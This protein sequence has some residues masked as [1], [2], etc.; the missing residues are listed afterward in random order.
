MSVITN[1]N[2]IYKTIRSKS[3]ST[4]GMIITSCFK[5][6]PSLFRIFPIFVKALQIFTENFYTYF[7]QHLR[8]CNP[9]KQ[10]N[11]WHSQSSRSR[12]CNRIY[13]HICSNSIRTK[14]LIHKINQHCSDKC[15][16]QKTC[17]KIKKMS[18]HIHTPTYF[19]IH[20][21]QHF[22]KKDIKKE[23]AKAFSSLL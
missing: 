5:I 3:D 4:C 6:C 18:S 13:P 16:Q 12:Y 7:L 22:R 21:M 23:N 20:P 14:K 17:Y 19:L 10:Y 2:R 11:S 1:T 8:K 15:A 9:I